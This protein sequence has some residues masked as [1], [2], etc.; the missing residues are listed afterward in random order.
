MSAPTK[1]A[2]PDP[3]V[4]DGI[5][6]RPE[7]PTREPQREARVYAFLD[8]GPSIPL[9]FDWSMDGKE[10]FAPRAN[11][12]GANSPH[13]AKQ[14]LPDEIGEW[15]F[16]ILTFPP[17]AFERFR[18]DVTIV[19]ER[20]GWLSDFLQGSFVMVRPAPRTVIDALDPDMNYFFPI[21][22]LDR[23][24]GDLITGEYCYWVPRR[25]LWFRPKER[26]GS[27]KRLHRV[28]SYGLGRADVAW[29]LAN[30]T[31][32]QNLLGTLPL[33]TLGAQNI[34]P[35]MSA[36][37]FRRFKEEGFTGL[38]EVMTEDGD[39]RDFSQCIGHF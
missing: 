7:T 31:P 16:E 6:F 25:R 12:W 2:L 4:I 24:T 35:A 20:S 14:A 33:W 13:R 32:L 15:E 39:E 17:E 38:P 28:S 30:N 36:H 34:F 26:R 18:S 21:N 9:Q 8:G 23:D 3:V 19:A 10:D 37:L 29:E 11:G 5:T 1:S 22:V 27:D